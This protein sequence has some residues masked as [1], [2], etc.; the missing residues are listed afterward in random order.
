M[1]YHFSST[2]HLFFFFFK[3]VRSKNTKIPLEGDKIEVCWPTGVLWFCRKTEGPCEE[4]FSEERHRRESCQSTAQE[5]CKDKVAASAARINC[6]QLYTFSLAGSSVS[7]LAPVW[8]WEHHHRPPEAA[9]IDAQREQG[10]AFWVLVVIRVRVV[11]VQPVQGLY[12][13]P[14]HLSNT[15]PLWIREN[16]WKRSDWWRPRGVWAGVIWRTELNECF[17]TSLQVGGAKQRLLLFRPE[18]RWETPGCTGHRQVCSLFTTPA[19]TVFYLSRLLN[20]IS[21]LHVIDLKWLAC[22]S[23]LWWRINLS[24]YRGFL[25]E[26]IPKRGKASPRVQDYSIVGWGFG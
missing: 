21:G 9:G 3:L 13:L 12:W 6:H 7:L 8:G 18:P 26:Q 17:C 2:K 10:T 14:A 24:N 16:V 5:K 22:V 4:G 11:D 1:A 25:T 19:I 23:H 20:K 15:N